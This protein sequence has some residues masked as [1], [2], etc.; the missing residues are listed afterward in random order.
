M[1]DAL[2]KGES[3]QFDAMKANAKDGVENKYWPEEMLDEFKRVWEEKVV[4]ELKAE[5]P[6]FEEIWDDYQKFRADYA[7]WSKWAYLPRPGTKRVKE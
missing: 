5:D 4:R 2:A 1:V 3:M 7:T 6:G